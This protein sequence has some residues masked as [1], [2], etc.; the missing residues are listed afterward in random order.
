MRRRCGCRGTVRDYAPPEKRIM[1]DLYIQQLEDQFP[2]LSGPAFAAAR[3]RVRDAG[4]SVLQSEGAF[5]YCVL[6]DGSKE[7]VK[8]IE[9]P[10]PTL[11]GTI[12]LIQ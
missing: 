6:P 9:P 5:L 8:R 3:Q 11:P 7:V 4:Q 2:P 1:S 10:T 12:F